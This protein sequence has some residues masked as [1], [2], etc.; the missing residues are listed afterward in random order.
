M[1]HKIIID[2]RNMLNKDKLTKRGFKYQSVGRV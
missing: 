1:N 2:F